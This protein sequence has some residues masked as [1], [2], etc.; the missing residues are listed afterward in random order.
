MSDKSQTT[1]QGHCASAEDVS[2]AGMIQQMP[3]MMSQMAQNRDR[4]CA[5]MMRQM[6][7]QKK[8]TQNDPTAAAPQDSV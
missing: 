3:P 4:N 1:Q 7:G 8:E 2:M 5:D 6:T